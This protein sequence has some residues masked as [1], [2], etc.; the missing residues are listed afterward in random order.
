[1]HVLVDTQTSFLQLAY[2]KSILCQNQSMSKVEVKSLALLVANFMA[3]DVVL[4][5]SI[6]IPR[7]AY[8]KPLLLLVLVARRGEA[9]LATSPPL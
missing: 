5:S 8:Q 2:W 6:I 1:M 4:H 9:M 7:S 3:K